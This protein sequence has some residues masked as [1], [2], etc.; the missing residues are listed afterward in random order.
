[1]GPSGDDIQIE[2]QKEPP[3]FGRGL[4]GEQRA[5]PWHRISFSAKTDPVTGQP[6]ILVSEVDISKLK[7]ALMHIKREKVI[8]EAVPSPP[9]VISRRD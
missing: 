6:S 7:A 1:M 4:Q 8:R 3:L 9:V 5:R 2:V